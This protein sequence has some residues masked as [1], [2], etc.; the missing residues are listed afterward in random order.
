[1]IWRPFPMFW[2]EYATSLSIRFLYLTHGIKRNHWHRWKEL[3]E[4]FRPVPYLSTK[5]YFCHSYGLILVTP[6]ILFWNRN[7][8]LIWFDA[9]QKH[10]WFDLK[11]NNF[12]D[13]LIWIPP[14]QHPW[15]RNRCALREFALTMGNGGWCQA[16]ARRRRRR[17]CR[18]SRGSC[19][20][21]SGSRGTPPSPAPA[22]WRRTQRPISTKHAQTYLRSLHDQGC[23][24]IKS[25]FE[26]N[27]GP[28]DWI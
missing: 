20:D 15:V 5:P 1:M 28:F 12:W 21:P 18:A 13:D 16:V 4:T 2:F 3:A 23:P 11:R 6:K 7:Q 25:G 10:P 22:A 27:F 14:P 8:D 17:G 19:W 26:W 9:S 24:K